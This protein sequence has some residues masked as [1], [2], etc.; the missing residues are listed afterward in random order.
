VVLP[1]TCLQ[2]QDLE[3]AKL[4]TSFRNELMVD[5]LK[6]LEGEF[7]IKF[8]Y[9][10]Q[11]IDTLRITQNFYNTPLLEAIP[12]ILKSVGF[13]YTNYH[14]YAFIIYRDESIIPIQ[15]TIDS[16]KVKEET[17]VI[18]NNNRENNSLTLTLNGYVRDI[19]NGEAVVGATVY[20]EQLKI[21][22]VTNASGFYSITIPRGKYELK[23]F[24]IGYEDEIVKIDLRSSGNLNF[25]LYETAIAL[26]TVTV[27]DKADKMNITS[28]DVGKTKM[29]IATLSKIPAFMGE[30]DVV[31]SLTLMP[32]V[33][34]VG[35][36][37]SGFNIRGG[38]ADQNLILQD[39]AMIFNPTHLFGFFST[40]NP[41]LIKD[42]T[43]YKGSMPAQYGGRASSVL[44]VKLREGNSKKISGKG[45]LGLIASRFSLEGPFVKDKTTF[46]LGG[47]VSYNNL[48]LRQIK[49]IQLRNS[50]AFFYDANVKIVH[51]FNENNRL[52]ISAY[53][54]QDDFKLA[55]DTTFNWR[56]NNITLDWNVVIN[57]KLFANFTYVYGRYDSDISSFE[58]V[59]SFLLKSGVHYHQFKNNFGFYLSDKH[60]IDFGVSSV[61]YQIR[62]ITQNPQGNE[63]SV[64]FV[65]LQQ[66]QGLESAIYI[67]DEIKIS[68]KLG[69]SLGLR[70]SLY[71]NMG[72]D[73]VFTYDNT[74][75][76]SPSSIINTSVYKSGQLINTYGGLEPRLAFRMNVD[77]FSSLKFSYTKT[78]QYIHQISNSAVATPVD[79]WQVSTPNIKPQIADQI[80]IGY[81]RNFKNNT[82]EASLEVYYKYI[83]NIIDYKDGSTLFL[84]R[85]LDADLLA[86]IGRTYGVEAFIKK[87]YGRLRGW[88]SYTF[89][90]SLRRVASNFREETIN[91]GNFYPANYD[92]PHNLSL[93]GNF[94][95]TRRISFNFNFTYSTG[96]PVTAPSSQYIVGDIVV[97]NF[98]ERNQYRIPNYHRLDV[99]IKV[100]NTHRKVTKVKSN[101]LISVYNVYSRD[102]VFSVF[103]RPNKFH[104]PQAYK[105][106][107]IATAIPTFTYNFEF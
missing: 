40:Y 101:F 105:L 89:S 39:E 12:I 44:D 85:T 65:G 73:T 19:K 83:K 9:Q 68:T 43:L 103:F 13:N 35:E 70:Y 58:G 1:F 60:Q 66:K 24:S 67:N 64:P 80:A 5:V 6:K 86:G 94:N 49:N 26:K 14:P 17:I 41:D 47:R 77:E 53:S 102:N 57:P 91:L 63:S 96:R 25:N 20:I 18:F 100:E 48:V 23:I 61:L 50:S 79:L 34:V 15:I 30:V 16:S 93:V 97:P 88:I 56:N 82:I 75:P 22:T 98:A 2:A 104:S 33:Q 21:G 74:E 8:Y 92:K 87:N 59:N 95:L 52:S 28:M 45:G 4:S 32:G 29:S 99:S 90:R 31:K 76:K 84:N 69:L 36:N 51:R 7:S 107:I 46:V 3:S 27:T 78:R 72:A 42:V 55:S 38:N 11:W 106:S 71:A 62:P 10:K 37:S 81:F 54:S